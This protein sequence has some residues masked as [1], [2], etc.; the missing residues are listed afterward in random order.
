MKP[1]KWH[2][3]IEFWWHKHK[4]HVSFR[5]KRISLMERL[6][7]AIRRGQY[8]RRSLSLFAS[9][10]SERRGEETYSRAVALRKIFVQERRDWSQPGAP[11]V[12]WKRGEILEWIEAVVK[13][14]GTATEEW[15][16]VGYYAAQAPAVVWWLYYAVTPGKRVNWMHASQE[17][18]D[19][20][21]LCVAREKFRVRATEGDV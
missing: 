4:M 15:G 13:R 1:M 3:K 16:G 10:I 19:R 14:D 17:Q 2:E 8:Y 5:L 21:P 9:E 11:Q 20:A 7:M 18:R 12:G 6:L